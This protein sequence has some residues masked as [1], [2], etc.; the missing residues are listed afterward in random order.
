MVPDFYSI[1]YFLAHLGKTFPKLVRTLFSPSL[2]HFFSTNSE[3][4][5]LR[6]T[7]RYT[8]NVI[9]DLEKFN[10]QYSVI[11]FKHF[12][13]L[14]ILNNQGRFEVSQIIIYF[15]CTI[16]ITIVKTQF[17]REMSEHNK[18]RGKETGLNH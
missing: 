5:N 16:I 11:V 4:Q 15:V 8:S 18:Q 14:Q 6:K 2:E 3:L 1:T 13:S 7:H 12:F 10:I 17:F 9:Y